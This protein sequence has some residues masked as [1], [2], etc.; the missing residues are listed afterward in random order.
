[1]AGAKEQGRGSYRLA[2]RCYQYLQFYEV[3]GYYVEIAVG[4]WQITLPGKRDTITLPRKNQ[5]TR[6]M[7][8]RPHKDSNHAGTLS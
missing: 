5:V 7:M 8:E 1:M 3:V 4:D 2:G 6:L